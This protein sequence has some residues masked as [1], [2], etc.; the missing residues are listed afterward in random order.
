MKLIC[1]AGPVLHRTTYYMAYGTRRKSFIV[2]R[3][4]YSPTHTHTYY[5]GIPQW[6]ASTLFLFDVHVV[7]PNSNPIF[8]TTTVIRFV[9]RFYCCCC[10]TE[11][12]Y[13]YR[14]QQPAPPPW[15]HSLVSH[16]SSSSSLGTSKADDSHGREFFGKFFLRADPNQKMSSSSAGY[17]HFFSDEF[18][19]FWK[20]REWKWSHNFCYPNFNFFVLVQKQQW[21]VT[22]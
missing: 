19:P 1:A 5:P 3:C 11:D 18:T 8:V 6:T 21:M 14:R 17:I 13:H 15:R 9:C 2:S 12:Y 10:C 4:T 22:I 7:T 20:D 16:S